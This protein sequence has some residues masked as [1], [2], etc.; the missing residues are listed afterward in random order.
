MG[1]AS[2]RRALALLGAIG[3]GL[4]LGACAAETEPEKMEPEKA[5]PVGGDVIA[6]LSVALGDLP[7]DTGAPAEP[8][9]LVVGQV[10]N[11][12]V[13]DDRVR[14]ALTAEVSDP[15]VLRFAPGRADGSAE[16]NPGLV[17]LA[18]GETEVAMDVFFYD[19]DPPR[20]TVVV[21]ER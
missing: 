17:A 3:L 15:A 8:L 21:S 2:G 10:L 14:E 13:D 4:T 5:A 11:V 7:R 20:F 9:E 18:P 19:W 1:R 12:S 16:F 6:P